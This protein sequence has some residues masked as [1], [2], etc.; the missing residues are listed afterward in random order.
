MLSAVF[1]NEAAA[2][3]WL[4]QLHV[5]LGSTILFLVKMSWSSHLLVILVKFTET[6]IFLKKH[7]NLNKDASYN[8]RQIERTAQLLL[9]SVAWR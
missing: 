3:N 2:L 7:T 9:F 8:E 1:T 6:S 4:L 5:V